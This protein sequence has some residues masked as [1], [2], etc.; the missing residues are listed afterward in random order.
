MIYAKDYLNNP[1]F[2]LI[3]SI[4]LHF[5]L[6]IAIFLGIPNFKSNKKSEQGLAI[7]INVDLISIK[8]YDN[9][10]SKSKIKKQER[11][12]ILNDKEEIKQKIDEIKSSSAELEE[13]K[14][15]FREKQENFPNKTE[16]MPEATTLSESDLAVLDSLSE[17]ITSKKTSNLD[18][19]LE[20][21]KSK[22]LAKNNKENEFLEIK[23]LNTDDKFLEKTKNDKKIDQLKVVK[24][25]VPAPDANPKINIK[26]SS[27]KEQD[28]QKTKKKQDDIFADSVLKTLENE[29]KKREGSKKGQGKAIKKV[30]SVE[31]DDILELLNDDSSVVAKGQHFNAALGLSMSEL[32]AIRSQ[33]SRAW[34]TSAFNGANENPDMEVTLI[35]ELDKKGNIVQIKPKTNENYAN[36]AIYRVFLDSAIRAIKSASPLRGLSPEKYEV[37]HEIE[38]RFDASGMIY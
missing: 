1:R 30:Q 11:V 28:L 31:Q 13:I 7:P 29:T 21:A 32:S 9:L 20:K 38:V 4:V 8:D 23:K 3:Y 19:N 16:N 17:S 34:N 36:R 26:S 15:N 35:L 6:V 27:K 37:W 5:L 24:N 18:D 25:P 33:L 14:R 10:P 22:D 12:V 2:S